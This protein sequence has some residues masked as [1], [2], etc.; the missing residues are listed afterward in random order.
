MSTRILETSNSMILRLVASALLE[1]TADGF[2]NYYR[3]G[4][5]VSPE[6]KLLDRAFM[7]KLTAPQMT[8][9]IGGM[10]ALNTN[11]GQSKHGIFT[12]R[13]EALTNDFFVNLLDMRTEWK[14]SA[15]DEGRYEGRDRGTGRA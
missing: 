9:L 8:A 1:P 15:S 6:T 11:F 7:L 13:H 14:R 5:Q 3:A 2:R 12:N 4:Q 10:R